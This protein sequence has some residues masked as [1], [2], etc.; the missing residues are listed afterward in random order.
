MKPHEMAEV[1]HLNGHGIDALFESQFRALDQLMQN[2]KK[3]G[4]VHQYKVAENEYGYVELSY[5]QW[6]QKP[7]LFVRFKIGELK[8]LFSVDFVIITKCIS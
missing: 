3:L 8:Q 2:C 7:G 5:G 4:K 6:E 1:V